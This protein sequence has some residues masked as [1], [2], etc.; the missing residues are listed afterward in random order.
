MQCLIELWTLK[1]KAA[2]EHAFAATFDIYNVTL[3]AISRATFGL[4]IVDSATNAQLQLLSSGQ[5]VS[6]PEKAGEPAEFSTAPRTPALEAIL[7][8]VESLETTVK[9]PIPLIHGWI[10]LKRP[11][12]RQAFALKEALFAKEI[13]ERTRR[14]SAGDTSQ[15]CALDDILQRESAAATKENRKPNYKSR[16]ILD[17][18]KLSYLAFIPPTDVY[19]SSAGL[20]VDMIQLQPQL[21]GGS[22]IF[23]IINKLNQSSACDFVELMRLRQLSIETQQST[24]SPKSKSHTLMQ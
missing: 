1:A 20:L 18:V 10:I 19:S 22:S 7:T 5:G 23:L 24:K 4:D 2:Q 8:L 6:F 17:E 15:N 3:D 12:F 16:A 14:I 13:D 21:R 11:K 9:S